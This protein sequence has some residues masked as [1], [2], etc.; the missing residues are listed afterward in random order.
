MIRVSRVKLPRGSDG[1]GG[2]SGLLEVGRSFAQFGGSTIESNPLYSTIR[3]KRSSSGVRTVANDYG[4][5]T[6][7]SSWSVEKTF[8]RVPVTGFI[9]YALVPYWEML[10]FP[11]YVLPTVINPTS[12]NSVFYQPLREIQAVYRG[13]G[14][15]LGDPKKQIPTF[16]TISPNDTESVL[17]ATQSVP[18][19]FGPPTVTDIYR[20]LSCTPSGLV[21]YDPTTDP[22]PMRRIN[23]RRWAGYSDYTGEYDFA[24]FA[25]YDMD[26]LSAAR[27]RDLR[28]FVFTDSW[29]EPLAFW[30]SNTVT[31]YIEWELG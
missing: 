18:Q 27:W 7:S 30:D 20:D 22:D 15:L 2:P 6:V 1:A 19:E 29:P 26:T 13:S 31:H 23:R 8:S 25:G 12:G 14:G 11:R 17:V 9:D 3:I 4:D 5:V 28:G 21:T 24:A 16:A 10:G